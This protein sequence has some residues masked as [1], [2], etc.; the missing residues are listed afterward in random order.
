[1]TC[2]LFC[3]SMLPSNPGVSTGIVSRA[4]TRALRQV[5]LFLSLHCLFFSF[6]R[7]RSQEV[8]DQWVVLQAL[9]PVSVPCHISG[10]GKGR[11]SCSGSVVAGAKPS[12]EM[13]EPWEN[14]KR[15]QIWAIVFIPISSGLNW[16]PL[17]HATLYP[18]GERA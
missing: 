9:S 11:E 18:R 4:S 13:G 17:S 5:S 6:L 7:I 16:F 3:P 15:I 12:V 1:M 2:Y 8:L 14:A 10:T